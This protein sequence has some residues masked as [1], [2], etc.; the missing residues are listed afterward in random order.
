MNAHA[1]LERM[2]EP[3][4]LSRSFAILGAFVLAILLGGWAASGQFEN[5]IL[6]CVWFAAVMI[7]LF[8]QDY[9]WSPMLIITSLSLTTMALGFPLGGTEIGVIILALTFPIKLA[10]KTLRKAEPEM[11]PGIIFWLLLGY[12]A[13]HAIVIL[14]YNKIDGA[15]Q[16]KNIVKSYYGDLTPL[17]FYFLLVRYCQLRTVRLTVILLYF[18][19]MFT[20]VVSTFTILA[21][22]DFQPFSDLRIAVGWLDHSGAVGILRLNAVYLF[23]GGIAFWPVMKSMP[24]K[25]VLGFG[26]LLGTLGTLAGSGRIST[27]NCVLAGVFFAFIRRR[28]WLGIPFIVA[29]ALTSAVITA[30][31]SFYLSLPQTI[32]RSIAPLNLSYQGAEA[33][34]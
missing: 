30:N 24:Q 9:W 4:A 25:M 11:K 27:M 28:L 3:W 34:A 13:V 16:L 31:P 19:I 12:V 1:R 20:V 5:L 6:F 2:S 21:G 17:I 29:A 7:I 33:N 15:P 22:I 10:M 8:V 14:A 32:Q 23:I 26:I 18:T